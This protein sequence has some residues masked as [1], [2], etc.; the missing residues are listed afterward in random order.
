MFA[1]L[2]VN[3]ALIIGAKEALK[4]VAVY[5][6]FRAYL[7]GRLRGAGGERAALLAF[8]SGLGLS[9]CLPAI[10]FFFLFPPQRFA[11]LAVRLSGF[12]FFVFFMASFF[13]VALRRGSGGG[14]G[15]HG[16]RGVL[17]W[18]FAPVVFLGTVF[19]FAPDFA[20]SGIFLRE[21]AMM[22]ENHFGVL[23]SALAGF[24]AVAALGFL[25]K[26]AAPPLGNFFGAGEFLLMMSLVKLLGG[27]AGGISELSLIASVQRGVMKFVH[28]AVHQMFVFFMVPDHPLLKT[29]LWNFIGI[30]FGPQ[31]AMYAVLLMLLAP[32]AFYLKRN[33][34]EPLPASGGMEG[35]RGAE[36]RAAKA[37]AIS[38]RRKRA[39]P[40]F[41]FIA[42]VVAVWFSGKGGEVQARYNPKPAPVVVDA[43][44]IV[45]PI[46]APGADLLDGRL[47]K[48]AVL[49]GEDAVVF[50]IIKKPDGRLAVCLDDCEIC[51]P[52]G[53]AQD[54]RDVI[55]LY[56]NTPIPI[57]TVSEP[58]GCNPIPLRARIT[59]KDVRVD[60]EYLKGK[61][62]EEKAKL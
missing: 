44:Q 21:L 14:G 2:A 30:F 3:E 62:L 18:A 28:D 24:F 8:F 15:V 40:A 53:Y 47:H 49:A 43:G 38:A 39:L 36:L 34:L 22:R 13:V 31:V 1:G 27:G 50:F 29:T 55:C 20:G 60:F 9:L 56:C 51:P 46:S 54:G 19:Y 33:L 57:E 6:F 5:L 37:R 32:A 4:G 10:E 16:G 48:F 52:K 17:G 42:L 35:L 12:G 7:S 58:G 61:W 25:V 45:I 26:R 11:P 41:V 23:V 59:E